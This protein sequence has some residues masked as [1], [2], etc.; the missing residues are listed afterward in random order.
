MA[1]VETVVIGKQIAAQDNR[2]TALLHSS[3]VALDTLGVWELCRSDA[4]P[5]R[6]IRLVD[7]MGRIL[8]LPE[9]EFGA[10]EIGLDSFGHNIENRLLLAAL[11]KRASSLAALTFIRGK[12]E[13][14]DLG[15]QKVTARVNG[16]STIEARL[17]IGADGRD[18]ICRTAA[19]IIVERRSYPQTAVTLN[20]RHAR[21]HRDISTEFHTPRGPFT[22]VPLPGQ[23]SSVVFSISDADT[24]RLE[25][26]AERDLGREIE[27]RSH[28]ILGKTE[29]EPGRAM[30][31][32]AVQ[33]AKS[34]C[35]PRMA[36]VG[37]AAHLIPPIGAQGL[38]LGLRDA[39]TIAEVAAEAHHAGSDVGSRQMTE[40]YNRIRRAD[41]MSR[42]LLVDFLNRSLLTDFL[43][44]QAAR[45]ASFF[46]AHRIG[47]LRR[48]IMRE[49]VMPAAS[50]P[51]LMRGELL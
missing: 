30:F 35:G 19:G 50:Q 3:V 40:R 48:A 43:P 20:I 17:L 33:T 15:E 10:S 4:A 13:T 41:V 16:N 8:R 29:A 5:L 26:V 6:M 27:Q 44:W 25:W 12:V 23:R 49:G 36:L 24:S 18:S 11:Q 21:P 7:D 38:N 2:T 37:E 51:R 22:L 46:L 39:A 14:I 31:P 28:S 1:G 32:L 47:L 34:L 42:T 9:V 45:G